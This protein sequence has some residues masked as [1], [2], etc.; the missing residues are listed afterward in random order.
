M[1]VLTDIFG[2]TIPNPNIVAD[3]IAERTGF[4]FRLPDH[5]NDM[6]CTCACGGAAG[7]LPNAQHPGRPPVGSEVLE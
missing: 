1:V 2:L 7:R 5:F 6:L 4:D 3:A